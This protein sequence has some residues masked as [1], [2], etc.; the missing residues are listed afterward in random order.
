MI[1]Q[2]LLH[3]RITDRLGAGGM[4]EVFRATDTHLNRDVAIKVLP[5]EVAQDKERLGR[6]RREAQLLAAL[7]H[8]NIASIFGLEEAA[9]QPFLVLELVEGEDLKQRLDKGAIPLDEALEIAK[10]IAEALEEAHAHGIVHRD[11]KPANVKLTP[12]GKVKVL[13]FGLAKAWAGDGTSGTS[14]LD[15]SA[16]PTLA[17]SGTLAGVILGTAAYM[18]PEQAAGKAV[19]KRADI[20]SFGVVLFE[21][22]TGHPLFT[23][24]TASEILASVIKEEPDWKR[25]PGDIPV[26]LARLLRR[27]LKKKPRERLHDIADARLELE[28]AAQGVT[29]EGEAEGRESAAGQDALRRA[30]TRERLALGAV[31]VLGAVAAL[32]AWRD[33]ARPP[34]TRPV[35]RFVI[36][37]PEALPLRDVSIA[38]SRDGRQV[39]LAP[40]PLEQ[41]R[42]WV[43]SLD[44]PQIQAIPGTE[45]AI[46]PFWSPDGGTIGFQVLGAGVLTLKRVGLATGAVQTLCSVRSDIWS[47][48]SWG[49]DDRILFGAGPG[50][51][52]R[53][54]VVSAAG[55][56]PTVLLEPDPAAGEGGYWWPQFLPGGR[57]FLVGVTSAEDQPGGT[58]MSSLDAPQEKR[59]VLP[60][61]AFA[62]FSPTG[63]LLHVRDGTLLAQPFDSARGE[64]TGKASA[65]ISSVGIFSGWPEA[66]IGLLSASVA[67]VLVYAQQGGAGSA[68]A[69]FDR[70][71]TRV[72]TVGQPDNYR[73]IQLS[74]DGRRVVAEIAD[75]EGNQDLWTLDL[76][77]GVPTR[78]TSQPGVDHDPVWSPDSRGLLFSSDRDGNGTMR[79]H[80]KR[81]DR[82]DPPS[83]LADATVNT[84][85]EG[86][87]PDGKWLLYLPAPNQSIWALPLD[88]PGE[89]ELLVKGDYPFDE[90][91]V[92]PDGRWLAYCAGETGEWEVYV[93]PFRRDGERVRVSTAGGGQPRWRGDGRELFYVTPKGQ[94]MAVEVEEADSRFEPALPNELFNAGVSNPVEDGYSVTRDGQRFLVITPVQE[95]GWSL[96]V[97]L[98]WPELLESR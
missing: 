32:F 89:P 81:L 15:L 66:S 26:G 77:R 24:E 3:Y 87:S 17:R 79:L 6:F 36:D 73:Q 31:V 14:S 64:L 92:S 2:T 70:H 56:E 63:H 98:N 97:I 28:E 67:D 39:A 95:G 91:Q 82:S 25:L 88:R 16:S 37:V 78:V 21:M 38:V 18:S 42:L 47:I 96:N 9:G 94:L 90:P 7:N 11:L 1:G 62:R 76:S 80:H 33:L 61:I 83:L 44:S 41:R 54:L 48:S 93:M 57:R 34:E 4:G 59:L 29:E 52:A 22:L 35:V 27:C 40:Q 45:G 10:Q 58:W 23:G 13:D 72:G 12:D 74:P 46:A 5:P 55:G 69:W 50:N 20:W 84:W 30:R 71:G 65:V 8:T 43:R 75:S 86:V 53:I 85:A 51:A 68:L 49:R 60:E 19:D